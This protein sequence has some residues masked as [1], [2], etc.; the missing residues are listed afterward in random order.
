MPA[1]LPAPGA[2]A[3]GVGRGWLASFVVPDDETAAPR[4]PRL[5]RAGLAVLVAQAV[6]LVGAGAW[7][8]VHAATG[9]H[10]TSGGILALDIVAAVGA[11]S[12]LG[13]LARALSRGSSAA[14][15]PTFLCEAL[16]IPV[17]IGLIQGHQPGFAAA[18]LGT[19]VAVMVLLARG[20]PVRDRYSRG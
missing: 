9:A 16:C 7:L 13:F 15:T 8:G 3:G 1:F 10:V 6:A 5:M 12:L 18:V 14:R 19:A 11:A 4:D 17:G 20:L 2:G